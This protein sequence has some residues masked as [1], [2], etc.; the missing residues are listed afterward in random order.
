MVASR[1]DLKELKRRVAAA[2]SVMAKADREPYGRRAHLTLRQSRRP[3]SPW[4]VPLFMSS[5]VVQY[6]STTAVWRKRCSAHAT[7]IRV[8]GGIPPR[9]E[10]DACWFLRYHTTTPLPP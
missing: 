1:L 7:N 2:A 4:L 3:K 8:G 6:I 9:S 5:S 10:S